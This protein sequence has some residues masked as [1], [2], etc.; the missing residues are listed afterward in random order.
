MGTTIS[1]Q[2]IASE[3]WQM[4]EEANTA[5]SQSKNTQKKGQAQ[6]AVSNRAVG[7]EVAVL[8]SILSAIEGGKQATAANNL[9]SAGKPQLPYPGYNSSIFDG[10]G[11]QETGLIS[12]IGAVLALQ[13]K[14]NSNFWQT[15]WK[16]AGD[17]MQ[18]Q[19][20]FAPIVGDAIK[21]QYLQQSKATM[22]QADQAFNDAFISLGMFA[23]TAVTAGAMEYSD[24]L[25]DVGPTDDGTEFEMEE[26]SQPKQEPTEL[27]N[28]AAEVTN[29][30]ETNQSRLEKELGNFKGKAMPALKAAVSF[31]QR[32]LLVSQ[33]TGM[34]SQFGTG[35]NGSQYMKIQAAAQKL[36]GEKAAASQEG[37]MY[38][39][40]YSQDFS[41]MEELRQGSSQNIDNAMNILQQAANTITQTTTSMFR[42]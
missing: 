41:R 23:L 18:I 6:I 27:D 30:S 2:T 16:Q 9:G 36:E 24:A 29:N 14:S 33:L 7:S 5:L 22:A 17:S 26:I 4:I 25:E 12:I 8:D 31:M 13:A 40:F 1:N 19:V 3:T 20:D 35:M 39:Q 15:L 28:D 38:S 11:E 34:I 37:Q 10:A 21:G 32:G 42:G